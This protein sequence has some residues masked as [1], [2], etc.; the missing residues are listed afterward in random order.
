MS[1]SFRDIMELLPVIGALFL[2]ISFG[3]FFAIKS[4]LAKDQLRR[5]Y[6][7][8]NR[9]PVKASVCKYCHKEDPAYFAKAFRSRSGQFVIGMFLGFL[10]DFG[11][12]YLF[13]L[14]C[15]FFRLL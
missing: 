9:I 8:H 6:H 13:V 1:F 7:C 15:R 5:C 3:L 12:V 10:A 2:P 11:L 4:P 14:V